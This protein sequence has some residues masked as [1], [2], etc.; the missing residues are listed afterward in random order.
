MSIL[1]WLFEYL[2][3]S[4]I[5]NLFSVLSSLF[6]SYTFKFLRF[7][8]NLSFSSDFLLSVSYKSNSTMHNDDSL[9]NDNKKSK[10]KDNIYKRQDDDPKYN[11]DGFTDKA[12]DLIDK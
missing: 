12:F 11:G 6:L 10:G 7:S 9:N 4:F 2:S 5:Y 3:N 1:F 8:F